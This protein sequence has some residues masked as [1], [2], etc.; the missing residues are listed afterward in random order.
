MS[1]LGLAGRLNRGAEKTY[2]SAIARFSEWLR[3]FGHDPDSDL[4]KGIPSP[5]QPRPVPRQIDDATV[6]KLLALKLSRPAHAYVLLALY[7]ALR[8]HEIRV[9]TNR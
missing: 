1:S 2:W 6:N 3:E 4:T 5:K 8:V 9:I 7:Q